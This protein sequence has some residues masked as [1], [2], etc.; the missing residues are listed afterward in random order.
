MKIILNKDNLR[1]LIKDQK[2]LGFVPTMGALHK[3]HISLIRKSRSECKKVIIS[4]FVNKPQFNK[5]KDFNKYPRLL[6]NDITI[7]KDLKVD[8]LYV[9]K[10]KDIYPRGPNKNIK[11]SSF[12]KKLCGKKRPGHFEAVVDVVE[13]FIRIIKPKKIYLGEKD[14]QQVK[15]IEEFLSK[16]Y[17][18]IK[19]VPCKTI[20]ES[21]GVAYSSR[22]LLLKLN[23]KAIAS[24]VYKFLKKNKNIII[25][26]K[27]SIKS[28]KMQVL[29]FGVKNIEYLKVLDINKIIKPYKW[30][31]NSRIFIAYYLGSVRLI[32][33]F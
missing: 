29:K 33:N 23:E 21:D 17:N 22:N 32:D 8:Y 30:K 5:K 2:D 15:I 3:G 7:L 25:S 11:I 14:M 9:P 28:C 1:K 19:I 26:K 18:E 4:I 10:H 31:K 6:K 13:R 27:I 16:K 20:R 24:K 12:K